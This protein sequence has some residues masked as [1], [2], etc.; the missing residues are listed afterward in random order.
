MANLGVTFWDI[1]MAYDAKTLVDTIP[2]VADVDLR[3]KIKAFDDNV[4]LV[5][6]KSINSP[7]KITDAKEVTT[8]F[9]MSMVKKD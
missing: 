8:D 6:T 9:V 2:N 1:L 7:L 4:L 5:L 3:K